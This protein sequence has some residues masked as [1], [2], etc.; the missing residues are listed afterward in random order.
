METLKA[1]L[2]PYVAEFLNRATGTDQKQ[3]EIKPGLSA[4]GLDVGV[5]FKTSFGQGTLAQIPWLAC[6]AQGQRAS[7]E[8]VYPVLLYQRSENRL[9]VAYGVSATAESALGL[10]PKSWPPDLLDGLPSFGDKR[11]AESRVLKEFPAISATDVDDV[12]NAFAQVIGEFVSL[13]AQNP[14]LDGL[15]TAGLAKFNTDCK[16][17]GLNL[18]PDLAV[19]LVASLTTKPLCIL[20][21]LAGS[22]KTKLAEALAMWL[23]ASPAQFRLVAVGADW[24]NN[25]Q[26]LGYADALHGNVYRKPA[27]G[28]LDLLLAAHDQPEL[29][30]FLIL[31]EMNLSHVERY[32][33]DVLSAIESANAPIALHAH[34][35]PLPAA[36]GSLDQ[37]PPSIKLP[38]NVFIIGTVNVDETTYTFSPKVLDRANVIEFR[39][40]KDQLSAFLDDPARLQLDELVAS[41]CGKGSSYGPALVAQAA[42]DFDLDS[43]E[44]ADEQT[45]KSALLEA[46][47]LL[48]AVGA[49]FGFRTAHE[50]V[51]FVLLHKNLS[52]P[53]WQLA[54]ALDAQ[55]LQKLLP[56]LHGSARKLEPV[57]KA[58]AAFCDKH[59]LIASQ[60]KI[61][62]MQRRLLADG[63]AS[64]AEN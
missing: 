47:E 16:N 56:R 40:T 63:F 61:G 4:A 58:L 38:R 57:L 7:V 64:F 27:N 25:E 41:G 31:D 13:F 9:A 44:E 5:H 24:T 54:Q 32:F 14:V 59:S 18:A 28:A 12:V 37:V 22:G 52:G 62:R 60:E 6:F 36:P 39:A 43:L 3:V 21:G 29:P 53:Q 50:M 30:H 45:L 23:S 55:V 34:G 46:F 42:T 35:G 19:R 10:W 11:Y 8:G 15:G 1:E 49:E 26:L 17:A 51:R 2:K 20:T 33:A 48:A